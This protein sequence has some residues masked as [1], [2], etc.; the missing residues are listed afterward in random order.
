MYARWC[1]DVKA[2]VHDVAVLHDIILAFDAHLPGIAHG[3]FAAEGD[4]VF[5]LDDLGAYESFFEIGVY[6]AG[7]LR[8]LGAATECPGAYFVRAG[9]EICLQVEQCVGSAYQRATPDSS[10]PISARNSL[11]SS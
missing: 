2:E 7:C 1:L 5:V 3:A 6:D 4:V 8:G 9:G 10:R 11:R